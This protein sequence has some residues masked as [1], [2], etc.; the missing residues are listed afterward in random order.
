MNNFERIKKVRELEEQKAKIVKELDIIK[1]SIQEE[2]DKCS[3]IT[4]DLGY[5]GYYPNPGNKHRCIICGKGKDEYFYEPGY[6]VDA[7]DY[8]TQ[9]DIKDEKQ[10]DIK[11]DHIQ[12]IALGLLKF[13]PSMT[14]AQLVNELNNLIQESIAYKKTEAQKLEKK[15]K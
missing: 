12:T 10:C 1:K 13:K 4:V 9:Y 6:I 2:K 3:H 11:F 8:L 14:R 15:L 5:Y 7:S